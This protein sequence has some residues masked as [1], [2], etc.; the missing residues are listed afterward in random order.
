[1]IDIGIH[2]LDACDVRAGFPG[3]EKRDCAQLPEDGQPRNSS[4]QFGEWDPAQFTASKMPCLARIEFRNGGIL[5]LDTSFALNIREQSIM[6][7]S[8]LR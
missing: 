2:M 6:N 8:F 7:V 4:G 1:M 3:G 5:R